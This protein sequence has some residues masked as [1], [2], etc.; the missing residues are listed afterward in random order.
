MNPDVGSARP[1]PAGSIVHSRNAQIAAV[2]VAFAALAVLHAG[3]DGL[4]FGDAPLHA[5]SGFFWW[6]LLATTP[7]H[8]VDYAVRYFARYPI[9]QPTTYPPLFYLVE[10]A[11]FAVAGASPTVAKLLVLPCGM[12]IGVYTVLWGRRWI[13]EAAGWTGVFLAFVPGILTWSN[14]VMLNVPAT[15]LGLAAFY[16]FR[17]WLD[18]G[19]IRQA[20]LGAA[21]MA[22]VMLTYY[23]GAVVLG[24]M[25][26]LAAI[27]CTLFPYTTLFRSDRK[28]VV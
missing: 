21:L 16:H 13:G 25:A 12:V 4:W 17:R 8:P 9:V 3:N 20:A 5:G 6:D 22:A 11:A 1:G 26:A 19:A 15:A 10:G 18:T 7:G 24:P 14:A 23:P 28:S 27:R 2:V